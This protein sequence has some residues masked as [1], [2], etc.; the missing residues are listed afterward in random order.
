MTT[1]TMMIIM[2]SVKTYNLR[3]AVQDDDGRMAEWMDGWTLSNDELPV[4]QMFKPNGAWKSKQNYLKKT[5]I[6]ICN[7]TVAFFFKK[8]PQ[9][10]AVEVLK[11]NCIIHN[12]FKLGKSLLVRIFN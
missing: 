7:K 12:R 6:H 5:G 11:K 4:G 1:M 3:H 9:Y 10:S 2:M 8:T